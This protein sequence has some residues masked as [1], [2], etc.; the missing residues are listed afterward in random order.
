MIIATWNV[1][2]IRARLERLLAWLEQHA[3]DVVCLQELKVTDEEFPAAEVEAAGYRAVFHGQRTYNGVA[4]LSRTESSDVATGFDG[5][6]EEEQARLISARVGGIRF[7]SAYFPN[8]KS[9]G[10][11]KWAY[12]LDW[13]GRLAEHLQA[14]YR[15]DEPLVL[16][17]DFNVAPEDRDVARPD[18]WRESVLCH[19]DARSALQRIAGWGLVDAMRLIEAGP[20]PFSWWDYRMLAF[21]KGNGLRIDHLFV[22]QPL[23][24]RCRRVWVDR[25]QRK[26]KLPSD[27]APV[28]AEIDP[29]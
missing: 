6:A 4:I 9:V 20:G 29:A 15:P 14:R 8:G 17:G 7:L 25:E 18:E 3:P 5:G 10:S 11:D 24:T 12:K 19:Q 27:H 16:A 13:M 21:P 28:L 23:V 22:T 1:N 26:G 2:S